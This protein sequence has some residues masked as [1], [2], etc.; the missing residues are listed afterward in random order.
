MQ[1]S[2]PCE[3]PSRI[4]NDRS[5]AGVGMEENKHLN[6]EKVDLFNLL[7]ACILLLLSHASGQYN[8]EGSFDRGSIKHGE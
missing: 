5:E 1:S 4:S 8:W 3:S 7:K 2:I 6:E